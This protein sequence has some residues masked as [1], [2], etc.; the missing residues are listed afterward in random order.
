MKK[1][2][3]KA[4]K[5]AKKAAPKATAEPTAVVPEVLVKASPQEALVISLA[6]N[7]RY[8]YASLDGEKVAVSVPAWMAPNLLRKPLTI[9]KTPDSEHY[10]IFKDGN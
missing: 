5:S 2:T 6:N 3:K 1:T 4:A 8:V 7:P 10:E 9:I